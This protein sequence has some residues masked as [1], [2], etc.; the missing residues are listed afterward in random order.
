MPA[1]LK[2]IVNGEERDFDPERATV[3]R[4]ANGRYYLNYS[5][6]RA[7]FLLRGC[8]ALFGVAAHSKF[9]PKLSIIVTDHAIISALNDLSIAGRN[10]LD[11]DHKQVYKPFLENDHRLMGTDKK[12]VLKIT[13][14]SVNTNHDSRI[15][16]C[17][18]PGQFVDVWFSSVVY[19]YN[20][21]A[22]FSH[23]LQRVTVHNH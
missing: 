12:L 8:T 19:N 3:R 13:D 7:S 21:Y 11:V 20:A 10:N 2:V 17:I 16:G 15:Q 1:E 22:G 23:K 9:Q 4:A 5:G 14:D 18:G 6:G